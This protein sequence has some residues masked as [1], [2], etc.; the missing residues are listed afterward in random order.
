M[1]LKRLSKNKDGASAV[2]YGLLTALISL[3][4]LAALNSIGVSL[5]TIYEG[6]SESVDEPVA[7]AQP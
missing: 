6:V 1:L 2:E 7:K 4:A 3:A 5:H